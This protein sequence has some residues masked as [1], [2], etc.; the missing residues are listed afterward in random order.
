VGLGATMPKHQATAWLQQV[1]P[2]ALVVARNNS[3]LGLLYSVKAGVG[4]AALFDFL[5]DERDALRPILTG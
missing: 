4:L 3:V 5:V 1:A 2:N